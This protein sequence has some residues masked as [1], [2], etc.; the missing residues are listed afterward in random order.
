MA[1]HPRFAN[2]IIHGKKKV[3]F[4]KR[5][6]SARVSHVVIYATSPIKKVLGFCEVSDIDEGTPNALWVKYGKISGIKKRECMTYYN[7]S[8]NA[9][10]IKVKKAKKL[11]RPLDLRELGRSIKPPQ[12]FMYLSNKQFDVVVDAHKRPTR[13]KA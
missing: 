4:R 12:S 2:L 7:T 1:V 11:D 10:A 5:S 3:E 8:R 13:K 6:F 9:V